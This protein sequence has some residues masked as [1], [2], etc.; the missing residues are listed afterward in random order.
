MNRDYFAPGQSSQ[1][2]GSGADPYKVQYVDTVSL[3]IPAVAPYTPDGT[4][5]VTGDKVLFTNLTT[6]TGPTGRG[7]YQAAVVGGVITWTKLI[8]GQDT[9]V[10][11]SRAG[12]EVMSVEGVTYYLHTFICTDTAAAIWQDNGTPNSIAIKEE[13]TLVDADVDTIDFV[14]TNVTATQTA[15]GKVQVAVGGVEGVTDDANGHVS[16]DNSD[17]AN[18]IIGFDGITTDGSTTTGT[19]LAGDPIVSVPDGVQSVTGTDVDNT[20][21]VNPIVGTG[22][23]P[24]SVGLTNW[25]LNLDGDQYYFDAA[26]GLGTAI[27]TVNMYDSA[28]SEVG[29]DHIEWIDNNT[30]RVFICALPDDRFIGTV[31]VSR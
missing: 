25:I 9:I 1:G 20:D 17:P 24:M 11:D 30:T 16:V 12:D 21:P 31:K 19:G 27:P 4:A 15:V 13:G 29:Y 26:H 10:G 8:F 6:L 7:C 23:V 2:G 28:D 18:P 5:V 3:T 14:G 22:V